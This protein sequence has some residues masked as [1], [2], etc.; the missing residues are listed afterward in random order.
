MAPKF[1]LFKY[2]NLQIHTKNP[3]LCKDEENTK[4]AKILEM[5]LF[6]N[7]DDLAKT[8]KET[9][10]HRMSTVVNSKLFVQ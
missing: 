3:L 7:S 1:V 8:L 9:N 5:L 6:N 10:A 2:P 4:R